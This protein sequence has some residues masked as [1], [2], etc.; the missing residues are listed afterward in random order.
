MKAD[1]LPLS[2]VS[3]AL[4]AGA[5]SPEELLAASLSRI[6]ALDG[7]VHAFL[8]LTESEARAAAAGSGRR[9]AAKKPLGP[10]DGVPVA[11]KDI[12]CT[13][14]GETTCGS[15]N[16]SGVRAPFDAPGGPK[17][18]GAGARHPGEAR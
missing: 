6:H 4:E 5:V 1:L 7:R 8:R 13:E 18:E 16:L 3:D 2:Q 15:K 17:L 12:F 9:R 14:G 11:L 10:L